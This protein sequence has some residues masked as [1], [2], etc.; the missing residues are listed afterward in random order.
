MADDD[1]TPHAGRFECFRSRPDCRWGDH[2][3]R[4]G[5]R[6]HSGIFTACFCRSPAVAMVDRGSPAGIGGRSFFGPGLLPRL[7]DEDAVVKN[8]RSVAPSL[9]KQQIEPEQIGSAREAVPVGK[10]ARPE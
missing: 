7:D 10:T 6:S 3:A 4:G 9:T 5:T 2:I 8:W 1:G